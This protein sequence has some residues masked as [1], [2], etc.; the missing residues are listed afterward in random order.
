MGFQL[1][2]HDDHWFVHGPE[3]DMELTEQPRFPLAGKGDADS[4]L[5]AP[6]PGNVQAISIKIGDSVEKGQLL[7]VLEAMKMEHQITAP[8]DGTVTDI[9]VTVGD[10]VANGETLVAMEEEE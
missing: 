2:N 6:M 8:R 1:E 9:L 7:L 3:G 5:A 10:Q 4:G